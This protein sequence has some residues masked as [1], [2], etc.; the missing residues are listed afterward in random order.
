MR[1]WTQKVKLNASEKLNA[2][3]EAKYRDEVTESNPSK[4]AFT[5][6]LNE[7]Q[8]Q[9]VQRRF[10]EQFSKVLKER[11][12]EVYRK[13]E[14]LSKLAVPNVFKEAKKI[15]IMQKVRDGIS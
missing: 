7:E 10:D 13:A 4:E 6:P 8:R 2:E 11:Y 3:I 14:F 12:D 15:E 9:I 1:R 5:D